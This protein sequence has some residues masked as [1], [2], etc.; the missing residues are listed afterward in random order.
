MASSRHVDALVHRLETAI[1]QEIHG[2]GRVA[3]AYSGGLASTLIAMIARKRCELDCVV[4]GVDGSSDVLAARAA[5][6]HLDYRIEAVILSREDAMR[7]RARIERSHPRL[8][9]REVH[10]LIPLHAAIERAEGRSV[11]AGFGVPRPSAAML[12]ALGRAA[13]VCPLRTIAPR[14]AALSRP[15]LRAA[16][17]ALGLP[18][19]W[20][21]V[22]HRAPA[23]GAGIRDWLRGSNDDRHLSL[24]FSPVCE[25]HEAREFPSD[26]RP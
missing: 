4:A 20:A 16:A 12:A 23:D 11:L 7:I 24:R 22:S 14:M 26:D 21:R 17:T 13:V 9:R 6:S 18:R 2:R 15:T 3:L 1:A 5:K 19:E 10:N 8:P 25:N